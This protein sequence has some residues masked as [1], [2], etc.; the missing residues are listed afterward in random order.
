MRSGIWQAWFNQLELAAN[1]IPVFAT[2]QFKPIARRWNHNIA[3]QL[4]SCYK[5]DPDAPKAAQYYDE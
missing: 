4:G 5:I 3:L 2:N 1:R